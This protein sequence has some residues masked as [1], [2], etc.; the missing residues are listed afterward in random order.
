[1]TDVEHY[2]IPIIQMKPSNI[3]LQVGL[4]DAKNLPS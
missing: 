1:M 2:L 3:I 4:N